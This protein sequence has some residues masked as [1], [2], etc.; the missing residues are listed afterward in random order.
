MN[1][2]N[3]SNI[4]EML[5]LLNAKGIYIVQ[6]TDEESYG[7]YDWVSDVGG[8][9]VLFDTEYE[10]FKSWAESNAFIELELFFCWNVRNF[11][12]LSQFTT[13]TIP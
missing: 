12:S 11:L 5:L 10:A 1:Q 7:R 8:S 4:D 13:F 6:S 9:D 2:I 3:K